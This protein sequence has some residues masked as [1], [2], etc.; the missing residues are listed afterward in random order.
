MP[1]A[2]RISQARD[3]TPRRSSDQSHSSDKN[4][5]LTARPPGEQPSSHFNTAF[6][7]FSNIMLC[8]LYNMRNMCW[9]E[10]V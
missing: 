6:Y 3:G 5:Y 1:I 4:G 2:G 7:A 8:I 10:S 9:H